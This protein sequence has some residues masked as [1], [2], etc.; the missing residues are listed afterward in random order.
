MYEAKLR[1]SEPLLREVVRAFVFRALL[2]QLGVTYFIVVALLIL[3]LAWFIARHDSSWSVGFLAATVLFVFAFFAMVYVAHSRNTIGRFRQMSTPEATLK[4]DEQHISFV[5]EL[6]SS[7]MPWSA[8]TDV[9]RYPR[10]WLLLFSP[11][12]FV[13][14]PLDCLDERAREFIT[15]KTDRSNV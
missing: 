3:A 2:R 8:V 1:Y 13:T 11:S 9:W 10:F 6:G 7:T 14:L 15:R 4:Y 12:Q 5:S